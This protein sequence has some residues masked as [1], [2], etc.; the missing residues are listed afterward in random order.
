MKLIEQGNGQ[1]TSL[2]ESNEKTHKEFQIGRTEKAMKE[3]CESVGIKDFKKVLTMPGGAQKFR[4]A[5]YHIAVKTKEAQPEL[6]F[7][8]L[9]RA[10]VQNM[11]NSDYQAVEVTYTAAVKEVSSNKRQ[12]FYSPLE[13]I[14]FPSLVLNGDSFPETNFK[15][16]DIELINRKYGMMV[17]FERELFDDDQTGQIAQR[18]GQMGENARVQEEAYVWNRICDGTAKLEGVTLPK[19]ATYSTV[20][21]TT[22]AIFA[23]SPSG[24]GVNA[25]S[26]A[27]VSQGQI[28]AGWILAKGMLDQ[29]GR[30]MLVTPKL[31][32]VSKQDIFFAHILLNSQL[33]A[34]A[35]STQTADIG[36]VGSINSVNP[37]QNLVAVVA[38]RFIP[39]YGAIL[40]DAGKGFAFQRRDPQEVVQENPQSGPAFS[41]EVMRYK[42]RSRWEA[43]FTDPR[44]FINLNTSFAST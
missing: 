19:S 39:D 16:L 31:L 33:N 15:G 22:N 8:Q 42:T 44:F 38:S 36:K 7:G 12:E 27:R 25:T 23:G 43:D 13:R 3:L 40:I 29:S 2:M 6:M 26:A 30:P 37:I 20:Y 14:G 18:A 28:Q 41:Q 1:R 21:S 34:S 10:G 11:F 9:L 5:A 32:A 24:A 4:E 17:A 35:S